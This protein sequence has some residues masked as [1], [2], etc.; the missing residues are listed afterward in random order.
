MSEF[1]FHS[2]TALPAANLHESSQIVKHENINAAILIAL[3]SD[4]PSEPTILLKT[5]VHSSK[6]L[7][8]IFLTK[9]SG[10]ASKFSF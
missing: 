3:L 8:F 5:L 9:N 6:V 7:F 1:L 2:V 4:S 10:I